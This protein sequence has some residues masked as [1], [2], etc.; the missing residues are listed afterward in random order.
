MRTAPV[1]APSPRL[2][3]RR[4]ALVAGLVLLLALQAAATEPAAKQNPQPVN[5]VLV[6]GILNTGEVFAPMS[7]VLEGQGYRCFAPSLTPNDCRTGVHALARQLSEQIDARFGESQPLI[8]VGFSM[9]GLITRDYVQNLARFHRVRGVFLISTPNHGTLW[10]SF[11]RGGVGQLGWHSPFIE[12]LNRNE[13]VWQ[14]IPVCS[15]W[16]PWDLMILPA[17]SSLWSVGGRQEIHC[18]FH[19]WMVRSH[20][21]TRDLVAKIA[22]ITPTG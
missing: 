21:L 6:H 14:S 5:V 22:A 15:Y 16:T 9:G 4:L 10:A 20:E 7:R 3:C 2:P 18:L 1:P 8:L 12:A 11:A 17:T 19:P 13:A